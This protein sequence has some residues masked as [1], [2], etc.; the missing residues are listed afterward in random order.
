MLKEFSSVRLSFANSLLKFQ[1]R[2]LFVYVSVNYETFLAHD[3]GDDDDSARRQ[4]TRFP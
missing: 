2:E 1:G 3:P 4:V